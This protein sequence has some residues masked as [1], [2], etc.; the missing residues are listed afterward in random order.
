[1]SHNH[2]DNDDARW[3]D[4]LREAGDPQVPRSAEH[5]AAVEQ[6][7]LEHLLRPVTPSPGARLR[8]GA[9]MKWPLAVAA[10]VLLVA[11]WARYW[12]QGP[13]SRA[14]AEVAQAVRSRPWVH[15]IARG[16][17]AERAEI[18]LSTKGGVAAS[19][20]GTHVFFGDFQKGVRR[21]YHPEEN[22]ISVNPPADVDSAG[23]RLMTDILDALLAGHDPTHV[24][25][26]EIVA[27]SR[28]E[29][30]EKDDRWVDYEFTL[31]PAGH[32]FRERYVFRVDPATQL[33][34]TLTVLRSS[35]DPAK[36]DQFVD[37]PQFELD[38]PPSGPSDIFALDVPRDAKEVDCGASSDVR[39]LVAAVN[40][41]QSEYQ[42]KFDPYVAIVVP[43]F[44]M[45]HW[46]E[47]WNSVYRVYRKGNRWR[48]EE[49]VMLVQES[50]RRR[51]AGGPSDQEDRVRW[52]M[53][54]A[55]KR[56]FFPREVCDG[57]SEV[58]F[59]VKFETGT[60]KAKD[61]FLQV[62]ATPRAPRAPSTSSWQ[63][64]MPE[65]A[66]RPLIGIPSQ[67]A[68]KFEAKPTTGPAGTVLLER[69]AIQA[70]AI[71]EIVHISGV[72]RYWIDPRQDY[73]VRRWESADIR[74]GKEVLTD[75]RQAEKVSRSPQGRF[76]VAELRVENYIEPEKR[77]ANDQLFHYYI[78]FAADI[79]DE[80]FT[81]NWQ[82]P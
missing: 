49:S 24:Q 41:K 53:A 9:V 7:I 57:Q 46:W 25:R 5:I 71:H 23:F 45:E 69:R 78:D 75:A 20:F 21:E 48:I 47:S 60:P 70:A 22:V 26:T 12:G 80:V 62:T 51:E 58:S 11:G 38:Y 18:W 59:D 56:P 77:P 16:P 37:G 79:P 63:V 40:A 65:Q 27:R 34:K 29:V 30:R 28:R 8:A 50:F 42:V 43:H 66:G 2:T 68:V 76:F 14:W 64:L 61:D 55:K 82:Q 10:S 81:V 39:A 31:Q 74:D 54:E 33:P 36:P 72:S 32:S 6:A 13:E 15:G 19:R 17:N 44:P 73:L 35:S 4:L 3:T 1:M 67:S 52:W